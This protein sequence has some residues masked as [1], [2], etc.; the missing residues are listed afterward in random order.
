MDLDSALRDQ[1]TIGSPPDDSAMA[2]AGTDSC[3]FCEEYFQPISTGE[4]I[5]IGIVVSEDQPSPPSAMFED[6]GELIQFSCGS[7]A[8]P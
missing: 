4:A 6:F 5:G 1:S 8:V 7:T 2:D 3:G